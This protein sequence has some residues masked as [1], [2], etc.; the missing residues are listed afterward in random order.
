MDDIIDK[1]F[2]Q[3]N[4]QDVLLFFDLDVPVSG[5]ADVRRIPGTLQV[6]PQQYHSAIL[7]AGHHEK[8]VVITTVGPSNDLARVVD[9]VGKPAVPDGS[10]LLISERLSDALGVYVGD[11]VSATFETGLRETFDIPVSGI[12]TQ[13]FGLGAYLDHDHMNRLFRR[14]PQMSAVNV[15]L[16][17]PQDPVEF[18]HA[19]KDLPG[20]TGT[21]DMTKNRMSFVETVSQN[22][23]VA[24]TVYAILGSIITIGVC[25][26]AAR[27]QLSERAR[28][29]ASL[30]ILGFSKFDVAKVL[31]G[32]VMILV[33]VAQP[34][35]WW[36]GTEIARWMTDGFSSDLYTVPLVLEPSTFARASLI[37]L[38]AS[39]F[40]TA[41]VARRLGQLDL[42]SVMKTRE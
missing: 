7:T 31:V 15:T 38:T 33:I 17:N 10:G 5:L 39:V 23:L 18:E 4:R 35:G 21:I 13:Y 6:E 8:H 30:R 16:A 34:I 1:G 20:V 29:L 12:V 14:A 3:S 26:N 28:E 24:T 40:S 9:S 42:I 19:V 41:I 25:Y 37:V 2:Y 32:E 27:I 36:L 11:T 22:I